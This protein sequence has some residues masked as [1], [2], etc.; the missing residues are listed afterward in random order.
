MKRVVVI[1]VFLVFLLLIILGIAFGDIPDRLEAVKIPKYPN[2]TEWSITAFSSWPDGTPSAQICLKTTDNED[3][4]FSYYRNELSK[5]GWNVS[6][7][8]NDKIVTRQNHIK[9]NKG[10]RY[11]LITKWAY[12]CNYEIWIRS[13]W[14]Y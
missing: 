3:A 2:A 6:Q 13:D 14:S 8:E 7:V 10:K 1:I 9:I 12:D 11:G 4:V 5:N